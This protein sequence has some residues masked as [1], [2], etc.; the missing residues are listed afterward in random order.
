MSLS[1]LCCGCESYT[2]QIDDGLHMFISV[3]ESGKSSVQIIPFLRHHWIDLSKSLIVCVWGRAWQVV[4][5]R[6]AVKEK[7]KERLDKQNHAI[8]FTESL[9]RVSA[10]NRITSFHWH[11][12]LSRKKAWVPSDPGFVALRFESREWSACE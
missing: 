9:A 3:S 1:Q 2:A 8:V 11:S 4:Q 5:N 12:D 10:A 7:E 6:K